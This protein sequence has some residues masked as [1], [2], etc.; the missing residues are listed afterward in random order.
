MFNFALELGRSVTH[1]V[2]KGKSFYPLSVRFPIWRRTAAIF[3]DV[4]RAACNWVLSLSE[5][6]VTNGML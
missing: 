4:K 1:Q 5:M 6:N 3:A 2:A